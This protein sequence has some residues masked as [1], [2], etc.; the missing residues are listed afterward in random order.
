MGDGYS[1]SS[2]KSNKLTQL[3]YE[4][5]K[6]QDITPKC[7]CHGMIF[8]IF[9]ISKPAKLINMIAVHGL[10]LE[11]RNSGEIKHGSQLNVFINSTKA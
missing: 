6:L 3:F 2:L 4:R 1:N 10:K 7:G 11:I 5:N 9:Y 8:V